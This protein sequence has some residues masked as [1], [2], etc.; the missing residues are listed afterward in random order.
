MND[1]QV[2]ERM[3]LIESKRQKLLKMKQMKGSRRQEKQ[4]KQIQLAKQ[5]MEQKLKKRMEQ[6]GLFLILRG[7]T[8]SLLQLYFYLFRL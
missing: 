5:M 6:Q 2:R 8:V 4:N 1:E 3:A 7:D